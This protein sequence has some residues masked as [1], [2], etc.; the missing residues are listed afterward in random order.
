VLMQVYKFIMFVF[1]LF[2]RPQL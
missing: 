2:I 1:V